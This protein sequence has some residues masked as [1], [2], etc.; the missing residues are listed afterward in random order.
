C[1]PAAFR[2]RMQRLHPVKRR[3]GIRKLAGAVVELT[4]AAADSTK[5]EAQRGKI[6]LLEHVEKIVDDLVVHR[7]AELRMRVQDD[8]DGRALFLGRLVAAFQASSGTGKNDLGHSKLH[9]ATLTC[10]NNSCSGR[11]RQLDAAPVS[12]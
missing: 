11:S 5:I 2:I 3:S 10:P 9:L 7:A 12:S 6:A 8:G 1:H 4:L